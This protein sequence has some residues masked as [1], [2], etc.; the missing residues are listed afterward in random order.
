MLDNYFNDTGIKLLEQ[1]K[2]FHSTDKMSKL[3]TNIQSSLNYSN[4]FLP[5]LKEELDSLS[6]IAL[7]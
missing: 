4:K 5:S 1:S 3:S 2:T 6:R 7:T